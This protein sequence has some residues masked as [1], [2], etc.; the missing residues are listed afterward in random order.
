MLIMQS[1]F[2]SNI[3][4][5]RLANDWNQA[6]TA[7]NAG[8][9]RTTWNNYETGKSKP[10][11]DDLFKISKFFGVTITQLLEHDL[12]AEGNLILNNAGFKNIK[13]GNL[14]GKGIGNLITQNQ[15]Q[16]DLNKLKEELIA[17]D[18]IL[19][20]K[21]ALIQAL[22]GQIEALKSTLAL[23]QERSS[24]KKGGK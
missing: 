21:E 16:N 6:K 22:N 19:Q 17:K 13:D 8:F 9:N 23:I 18:R 12:S 14:K 4:I 5:L 24:D 3:K 10:S 11:V 15:L 1:F 20:D 7:D 2:A